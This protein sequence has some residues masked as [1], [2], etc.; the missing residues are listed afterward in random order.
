MGWPSPLS[1]DSDGARSIVICGILFPALSTLC[2]IGRFVARR[3]IDAYIGA[4]DW[5]IVLALVSLL[6]FV[7]K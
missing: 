7:V 5:F 4:D 2:V 3:R 1:L 6:Y